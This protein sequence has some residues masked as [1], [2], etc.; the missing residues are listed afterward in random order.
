[1]DEGTK[2]KLL[3]GGGAVA[4]I[5]A[6]VFFMR[7]KQNAQ[8]AA[9]YGALG[10]G[11]S[12]G[13]GV[14][15]GTSADNAAAINAA[16]AAAIEQSREASALQLAQIN[17][18][19]ALGVAN[20]QAGAVSSAQKSS[21]LGKI[22]GPGGAGTAAA[23]IVAKAATDAVKAGTDFVTGFFK[24]LF[25][26]TP[27]GQE[28]ASAAAAQGNIEG[29]PYYLANPSADSTYGLPDFTQYVAPATYD[30][31]D[32]Y[33]G[34]TGSGDS[35]W[36]GSSPGETYSPPST[37]TEPAPEPSAEPTGLA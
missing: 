33:M 8:S 36:F 31:G 10:G 4:S 5:V 24:E 2:K 32:Y 29:V 12:G 15:S 11:T 17:S 16:T 34:S 35:S 25:T 37:Y 7:S 19:T 14:S 30:G 18:T 27:A 23:P 3:Y 22:F 28:A 1:M 13:G 20:I 6:L 9:G 26:G 21:A